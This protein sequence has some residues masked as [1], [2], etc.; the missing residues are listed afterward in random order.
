MIKAK[1]EQRFAVHWVSFKFRENFLGCCF[2]C[3]EDAAIVQSGHSEN[4]RNSSKIGKT[5]LL[6]SFCRLR[7]VY[8]RSKIPIVIMNLFR[9]YQIV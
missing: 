4:F 8:M 7:Y 1:Q 9:T 6:H 3:I 5:F 2:I